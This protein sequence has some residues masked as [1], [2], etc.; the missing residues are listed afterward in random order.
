MSA[1]TIEPWMDDLVREL[2]EWIRIPSIGADPQ[3]ADAMQA[4]ADWT[5]NRLRTFCTEVG[6]VDLDG[7]GPLVIGRVPASHRADT[8]PT[9]LI[10]GHYDVQPAGDGWTSDPFDPVIRDGWIHG[11]G[12]SDDKGQFL[13]LITAVDILKQ[14]ADLAVNIVL[15]ADSAEET[16]GVESST[17]IRANHA[18]LAG[19]LL[20][21]SSFLD[22]HTPVI[23]TSTRG[24]VKF[25]L[26]CRTA[27]HD[28]HSGLAGGAAMNAY[29]ELIDVLHGLLPRDG[30]LPEPLMRN[31]IAP[32]DDERKRWSH[33]VSGEALLTAQ[34]GT[35]ADPAAAAEYYLRTWARPSLDI[36]GFRS[37]SSDVGRT[38]VI[39]EATVSASIRLAPGQTPQQ[40]VEFLQ[41][42][43]ETARASSGAGFELVVTSMTSPSFSDEHGELLRAGRVAF[44]Q[45]WG[46]APQFLR[47]GGTLPFV[48]TLSE[49]G[50][51][52]LLSGLHLPEGNAHGPD[53]KL[54]LSHLYDGVRLVIAILKELGRA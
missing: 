35:P 48:A 27:S 41:H 3:Y 17:W 1:R 51:P 14:R 9:Y 53:E 42:T 10:Y 15:L 33:L 6:F 30:R 16:L 38:A 52:F 12:S 21:D 49:L 8:A 31:A 13:A 43:I 29:H 25:E 19:A 40:V 26:T 45:V 11:R 18:G 36:H 54:K 37:S 23:N 4:A 22:E 47:A 2:Q 34:G 32:S 28:L 46:I 44:E 7:P 5:A 50:M 39:A 24:L 20:F